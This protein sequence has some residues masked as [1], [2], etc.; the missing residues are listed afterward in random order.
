MLRSHKIIFRGLYDK[1]GFFTCTHTYKAFRYIMII[2]GHDMLLNCSYIKS[3]I[4]W[5]TTPCFL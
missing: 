3:T 1:R 5:D 2:L 4:F